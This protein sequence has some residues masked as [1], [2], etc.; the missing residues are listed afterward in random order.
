MNY[1]SYLSGYCTAP[2]L[3]PLVVWGKNRGSP[4]AKFHLR[5]TTPAQA[6]QMVRDEGYQRVLIEAK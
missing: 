1:G 5:N 6:M 2:V 3:P 4:A